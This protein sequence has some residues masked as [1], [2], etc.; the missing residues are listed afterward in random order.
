MNIQRIYHRYLAPL[1]L[2]AGLLFLAACQA[3]DMPAPTFTEGNAVTFELDI[4]Q[5]ETA[6]PQS[7]AT[8]VT[9]ANAIQT[10][11][12]L[13]FD[14]NGNFRHHY[15]AGELYTIDGG[16]KWLYRLPLTQS[17]AQ[18]LRF[19]FF[20]N[21]QDEVA[22]ALQEGRIGQKDDLYREVA[23]QNKDWARNTAPYPMWGET[24]EAYD[25]S[26]A[27]Q[28]LNRVSMLR[29]VSTIDV[30][31][32]GNA[33]EA[34]GLPNFKLACVKVCDVPLKGYAAPAPG[35]FEWVKRQTNAQVRNEYVVKAATVVADSELMSFQTEGTAATNAIRGQIVVPESDADGTWHTTFLVGGY[36]GQDSRISWYRVN[37]SEQ[38]EATGLLRPAD[39]LRNKHY[40]L[41]ITRVTQAGYDTPEDAYAH[42]TENIH[43]TLELRP[44]AGDLNHVAYNTEDYLAT[45]KAELHVAAGKSDQ[46]QVLTSFDEGWM[47]TGMPEWLEVSATQGAPGIQ[48]ALTF[49]LKDGHATEDEEAATVRLRAGSLEL[50]VKVMP[51]ENGVIEYETPYVKEVLQAADF[52]FPDGGFVPGGGMA[53]LQGHYLIA[54]NNHA[55]QAGESAPASPCILIYDMTQ[56]QVVATISEW[57]SGG[58]ALDFRGTD[59]KPDYIDDVAVDEARHRLYVV[60]RQSCVEVFDISNPAQPTYVTRIGKWGEAAAY[61]QNRLSGSGAVLATEHYLLVRDDMSL[62]TYLYKDLTAENFQEVTCVT[63]DNQKMT[64]SGHQPAQW[65]VDPVD[66]N[67]YLTAY[68][69]NFRGIYGID[70][71]RA[72][73]YVAK[74][75]YWKQQDLRDRALPLDYQPTGLLVTS[76]KVY[77]THQDGS[78]DVFSRRVL[79]EAPAATRRTVPEKAETTVNLRTTTGRHGK[80]QKIY[81]DPNDTESFW[82]IDLTNHTLVRLN[83]YRTSVE[84]RP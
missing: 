45:D 14:T 61:T 63:R 65:A 49:S 76:R 81:Q 44:D 8:A 17:E 42:Q 74:G 68:D 51:G 55:G 37:F 48:S 46:L 84:I 82:S 83:M 47:L 35:H 60:R 69:N 24:P 21:L 11:D 29:A 59:D 1:C 7:R 40:I 27:G 33:T 77:V 31:L 54:A 10:L 53:F 4:P 67:I 5:A 56:K 52:G 78:L 72:D 32:N 71:S 15:P 2:T 62:D 20:A 66:G 70:P 23:F 79:A 64:H 75:Q 36:Y 25:C 9:R 41:N 6:T 73:D 18:G 19:V 38:D 12:V 22:Q 43:A 80:L 28:S 34:F 58:Q 57:T 3:D 26:A 39:L 13:A 16:G 30:V 50:S